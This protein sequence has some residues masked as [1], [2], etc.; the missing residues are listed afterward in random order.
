MSWSKHRRDR[1]QS[2]A[3]AA[4]LSL[5]DLGIESWA[6]GQV[7]KLQRR[8]GTKSD[9]WIGPLTIAAFV[10]MRDG[11]CGVSTP[12]PTPPSPE[13]PA[14][15]EL[16]IDTT[17]FQS[18][19]GRPRKRKVK[20]LVL[21]DTVTRSAKSTHAVLEKRKYSTHYLIDEDGAIYQCL[22]PETERGIHASRW[23]ETSIGIDLV[24]MVAFKHLKKGLDG[25][26]FDR[27]R[28]VKYAPKGRQKTV[29][30]YTAAQKSSL[31]FLAAHLCERFDL[32]FRV[33]AG[34]WDYGDR[35]DGLTPKYQGIVA[36]G[37][38]SSRRWDGGVGVLTVMEA[39]AQKEGP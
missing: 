27:K 31:S 9:G 14:T 3:S 19:H 21:H 37:H 26:R 8:V 25:D 6:P 12:I 4:G 11:L 23:N 39:G 15:T 36:H 24:S 13:V 16:L 28:R 30:D 1:N 2:R 29:V 35:M 20:Q 17:T 10:A 22:D 18:S 5:A 33:P 34:P 7:K 38:I 32:P